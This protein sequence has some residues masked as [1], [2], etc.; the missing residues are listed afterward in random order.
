MAHFVVPRHP[1]PPHDPLSRWESPALAVPSED[2]DG[3]P[4]DLWHLL[5]T[6]RRHAWLVIAFTIAVGGIAWHS[7]RSRPQ[8]YRAKAVVQLV[9]L[10][11]ALTSGVADGGAEGS[12]Y[13]TSSIASQIEILKSR[14]VA[15]E[16][17]DSAPIG[18][19]VRPIGFSAA[20]LSDVSL[21]DS[22]AT[23]RIQLTFMPAG[24]V[25]ESGASKGVVPYGTV[26][27]AK[28]L[29]FAIQ[30]GPG[31]LTGSIVVVPRES[32]IDFILVSIGVE[33][34]KQTNIIDIRYSSA[35][36]W[37]A[38]RVANQVAIAYQDV[39][40]RFAQ[41]QARR[42]RLFIEEQLLKTDAQLAEA[43]RALSTFR[44]R[45]QAF[46]SQDKFSAQHRGLV[47]LDVRRQELDAERRVAARLLRGF[48][49]ADTAGR[50]E[51]FQM[52]GSSP[53]L[54]ENPV[55]S[56]LHTQ[57]VT[58]E[59][60][61]AELMTGR[62]GNAPSHPE[63]RRLDTLIGAIERHLVAAVRAHVTLLDARIESLD[64]LRT[65]ISRALQQLPAAEAEQSRLAQ[66]S[67]ALRE[68]ATVL[69]VE[70]QKARIAE[71]A[72]VGQVEILDLASRVQALQT[73]GTR[74]LLF[75]LLL[76]FMT[77]GGA[78]ALFESRDH[79]IKRRE[80]VEKALGLPVLATIPQIDVRDSWTG[81]LSA[82]RTQAARRRA[83]ATVAATPERFPAAEAYRQ[84]HTNLLYAG[85]GSP[86]RTVL[87]TS[88]SEGEGKTSVAAN[89]A[90]KLAQQ[91][92]RVLLVDCDLHG[93]NLHRIFRLAQSPGLT[94]VLLK[95]ALPREVQQPT[96]I[97]GLFVLTAGSTQSM[98]GEALGSVRMRA[99][100]SD[101]SKDFDAVI[102]DS[103]PTLALSDSAI[104]GRV[105][106]AVLLV[107]RAGQ[108]EPSGAAEAL[109]H[110]RMVGA[111]VA[112]IVL[113]DPAGRVQSYGGYCYGYPRG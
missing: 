73:N 47:D 102:I 80:E 112:G 7:V 82:K 79:T 30:R 37:I 83:V 67:D 68:Q 3:A 15:A 58:Y 63:V 26:T 55:I 12:G 59:T 19:R 86:P 4:V 66:N 92:L 57:L 13:A 87:V 90:I 17:V 108:T 14:A 100:L 1:S 110:L 49:H 64:E 24:F 75:G 60:S 21:V 44:S 8:L 96:S 61:R 50:R 52:L 27:E 107:V 56:G 28:G 22:A 84:L 62:W 76:G 103:S 72:P 41:Q 97:P 6:L 16:V 11:H 70:Y 35:D 9:N 40:A 65:Q 69:R 5:A 23:G 93:A 106:D 42:R 39:N 95:N 31:I 43:E 91:R 25:V 104:L 34:R 94:D 36:P 33:A 113:N 88:P 98:A 78:A 85:G 10:R 20:L 81:Q 48:E 54:S 111:R 105:A 101:A 109:R 89:L 77:G 53:G 2:R 99:V 51:S 45:Q 18:T 38:Q 32:A 46:S 74:I 29:R 71:A